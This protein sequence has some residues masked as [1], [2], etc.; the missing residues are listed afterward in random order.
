MLSISPCD[1]TLRD[2]FTTSWQFKHDSLWDVRFSHEVTDR[3][4]WFWGRA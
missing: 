4:A 3:P 2:A 1:A